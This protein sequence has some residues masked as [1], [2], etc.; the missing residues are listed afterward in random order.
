MLVLFARFRDTTATLLRCTHSFLMQGERWRAAA[1]A[2]AMH[3]SM[4]LTTER[5][6][7]SARCMQ[8]ALYTLVSWRGLSCTI[9]GAPCCVFQPQDSQV[10]PVRCHIPFLVKPTAPN[11]R[12]LCPKRCP[13]CEPGSVQASCQIFSRLYLHS[14]Q[15][16][17]GSPNSFE[18]H[19]G[20]RPPEFPESAET[21]LEYSCAPPRFFAITGRRQIPAG[22]VPN[23]TRIPSGRARDSS[24]SSSACG[25]GPTGL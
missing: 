20:I 6:R 5:L 19:P 24:N 10:R 14:A 11:P 23:S 15:T 4:H 17:P 25:L 3:S 13:G 8:N 9:G 18:T 1:E 2:Q 22:R 7:S 21:R 16:R 12:A